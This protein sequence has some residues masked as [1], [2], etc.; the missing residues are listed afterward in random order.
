MADIYNPNENLSF[1]PLQRSNEK[2]YKEE[3][4][5]LGKDKN[6]KLNKEKNKHNEDGKKNPMIRRKLLIKAQ[7]RIPSN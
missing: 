3:E 2:E 5:N 7:I 6:S 1:D 4:Y